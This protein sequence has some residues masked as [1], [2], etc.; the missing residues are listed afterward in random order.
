[1]VGVCVFFKTWEK[2]PAIDFGRA[3]HVLK[4][5]I[6]G[7]R[8]YGLFGVRPHERSGRCGS[9]VSIG[10]VSALKDRVDDQSCLTLLVQPLDDVW[11]ASRPWPEWIVLRLSAVPVGA[12]G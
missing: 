8:S 11:A 7:Y 3:C 5:G 6:P 2:T 4:G 10:G 12:R 1:M 9:V